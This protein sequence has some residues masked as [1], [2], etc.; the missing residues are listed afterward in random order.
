MRPLW[1]VLIIVGVVVVIGVI[2]LIVGIFAFLYFAGTSYEEGESSK[3]C[4]VDSDCVRVRYDC[5][6]CYSD[7]NGMADVY[8][9]DYVEIYESYMEGSC[10]GIS[11]DGMVSSD[12][13]CFKSVKC[14]SGECSLV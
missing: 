2:L 8:N 7:S 12:P 5:C 14:V 11:C 9:K 13:S 6:G 1:I 10:Y 3:S 4:K